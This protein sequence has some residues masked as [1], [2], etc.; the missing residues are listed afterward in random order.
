V[1]RLSPAPRISTVTPG[2]PTSSGST[3]PGSPP[4]GLKSRQTTPLMSPST[5]VGHLVGSDAGQPEQRRLTGP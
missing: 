3:T 4:P 2:R 5:V 1:E